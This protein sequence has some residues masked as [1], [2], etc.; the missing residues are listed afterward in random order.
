MAGESYRKY[1]GKIYLDKNQANLTAK[2][3][4]Q[5]HSGSIIVMEYKLKTKHVVTEYENGVED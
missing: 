2:K 3:F 4:S 5:Y 1:V